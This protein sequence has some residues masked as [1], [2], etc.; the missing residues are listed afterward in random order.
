MES[1]YI[2]W[3]PVAGKSKDLVYRRVAERFTEAGIPFASA[4]SEHVGHATELAKAAVAAGEKTIVVLGGDGTVREVASAL[5]HTDAA[6]GIIPCG[7]G[8][9][10]RARSVFRRMWTGRWTSF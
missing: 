3:N 9:I 5:V 10:W 6:L 4:M 8:T 1:A 7:S 2:I